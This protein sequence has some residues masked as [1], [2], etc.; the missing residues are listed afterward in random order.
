M[1]KYQWRAADE[2]IGNAP[3]FLAN[4]LEGSLSDWVVVSNANASGGKT[5]KLVSSLSNLRR[6]L[7]LPGV[8]IGTG[9]VDVR[10]RFYKAGNS[11]SASFHFA[12]VRLK[13][14]GASTGYDYTAQYD[15][16]AERPRVTRYNGSTFTEIAEAS[17]LF[18]LAAQWVNFRYT[19][20]PGASPNHTLKVWYDGDDEGDGSNM[21]VDFL[22]A[23]IDGTAVGFG[24]LTATVA[25]EFDWMTVGT[26]TDDADVT[27]STDSTA[28]T[29]T[30]P[31]ATQT[32]ATTASGSV[33]TDEANGTLYWLA[34]ANSSETAATVK[35][36]SS[37][38][39][40]ATGT[41]SVS[42]T[43]LTASTSYY[44]HF[45]HRDAA[46]ND[47]TVSTSAQFT[48]A[49]AATVVKGVRIRLYD[50]ATAQVS[51]TGLTVAW[52]DDDDPATMGAPV[53]Q[54]T[55]DTTDANGWLEVDLDGS[56]ALDVDD[57]GFLIVYKAGATA[58]DDIVFA[59]RLVVQDIA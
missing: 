55:T 54:S 7:V 19:F 41:Q 33:S 31:S 37:Q 16:T 26:G 47:S 35:A 45:V 13:G 2:T 6:R 9:R 14:S 49:A 51:L 1:A 32:G 25:D 44:L 43:G 30:S 56:T 21:T 20:D 23:S 50:E 46:G 52:F 27:P 58:A 39:V 5:V 42:L 36:G 53:Y 4:G 24:V 59:G 29:L 34:S 11:T 12:C 57:P 8:N 18:A 28:P 17:S 38:S 15:G 10:G 3:A 40:S 22:S 48:T